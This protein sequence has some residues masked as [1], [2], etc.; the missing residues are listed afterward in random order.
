MAGVVTAGDKA[1]A[2]LIARM[3]IGPRRRS[4][5]IARNSAVAVSRN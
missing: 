1:A 5:S 2:K 3:G 4:P